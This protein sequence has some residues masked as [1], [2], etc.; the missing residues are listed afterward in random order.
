MTFL[1]RR[2][3]SLVRPLVR[4]QLTTLA[5]KK[6]G[7]GK[8]KRFLRRALTPFLPH[9]AESRCDIGFAFWLRA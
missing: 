7:G 4:F 6:G 1:I 9:R 8:Q 3:D 2:R 5:D